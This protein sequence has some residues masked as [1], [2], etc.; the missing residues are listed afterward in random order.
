MKRLFIETIGFKKRIS[1][2]GNDKLLNDIQNEILKQPHK[3]K[4]V[5]G[6]GGVRKLRLGISNKGKSG[7]YRIIYLDLEQRQKTYLLWLYTKSEEESLSAQE[8]KEIRKLVNIIK[9]E[10]QL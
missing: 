8:K 5:I 4:I 9:K 1:E 6:T 2:F 7:G 3:G 10:N